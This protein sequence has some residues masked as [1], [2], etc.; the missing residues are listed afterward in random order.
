MAVDGIA[1]GVAA[2]T[3]AGSGVKHDPLAQSVGAGAQI[4]YDCEEVPDAPDPQ[5]NQ[6]DVGE[7]T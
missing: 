7:P 2:A 1:G 6:F 4:A 3:Y 5:L